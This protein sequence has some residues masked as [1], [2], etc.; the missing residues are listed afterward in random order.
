MFFMAYVFSGDQS[1]KKNIQEES[2]PRSGGGQILP[3]RKRGCAAKENNCNAAKSK[4][5]NFAKCQGALKAS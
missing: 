2:L 1:P 3:L 5:A 4:T